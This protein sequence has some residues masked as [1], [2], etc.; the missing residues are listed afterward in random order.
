MIDVEEVRRKSITGVIGYAFRTFALQAIG[1][2]ATGLLSYYLS[3]KDFGVYFI[4]TAVVGMFNFLSDIGLAATLVQKKEEP[5]LEELRTTFTVQQLLAG[6]I[7]AILVLLTPLWT[8]RNSLDHDGVILLYVL[9]FS[10]FMASIKTIPSILLERKLEFNKL[11]FPQII[12][13]L[14]FY[15][16]AV[17]LAS[18]G[19]GVKSYTYA[20]L[21]RGITGVIAIYVIQRW[22]IGF[23]FSI[24]VMKD[25]FKFGMK[26]QLNDFLARIKDDLL[27]VVLS[28][29][30]SS[31][32]LGYVGWAKKISFYPYQ[33]TVGNVMSVT[34]PTFSRLQGHPDRLKRAIEKSI[35]FISLVI[36]PLLAGLCIMMGPMIHLIP[37]FVKWEPSLISLYFF[38]FNIAFAAVSSPLTNT[39]NAIGQ[40]NKTLKLMVMWTGL[41]WILTPLA[42][43]FFGYQG[44]AIAS[45]VISST[46][47]LTVYLVKKV[48]PI[49][50]LDQIWRQ[51]LASIVMI[52][53]LFALRNYWALSFFHVGLGIMFG[54]IIYTIVIFIAGKDKVVFEVGSLFRR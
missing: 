45:A 37:K 6:V 54:G 21:F 22:K 4:V 13:N 12:E 20:V 48:I 23:G 38:C 25:L 49:V 28:Q 51:A 29:F 24:K 53:A 43:H 16:V 41:T 34:F 52:V 31:A 26:F 30:V 17:I 7:F 2:V 1:L 36:F 5:T 39:L 3:P 35:Y 32:E 40:I 42:L 11:V 8:S 27:V 9:G 18:K 15:G 44:I 10:F 19:M 47:F 46:S 14:V 50:V 33:F